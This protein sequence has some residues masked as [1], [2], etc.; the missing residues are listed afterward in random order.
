M[1]A[2]EYLDRQKRLIVDGYKADGLTASEVVESV[3]EFLGVQDESSLRRK[4]REGKRGTDDW[5]D[6]CAWMFRPL[7][8]YESGG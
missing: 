7:V 2:R 1:S 6:G 5:R 4:R 3:G 8:T